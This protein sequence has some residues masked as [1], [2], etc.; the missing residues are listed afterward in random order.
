MAEPYHSD[1]IERHAAD[2]LSLEQHQ[3]DPMLQMSGGTLR[4]AGVAL[5][6]LAIAVVLFVVFYG[7][8]APAPGAGPAAAPPSTAAANTGA[9]QPAAPQPAAPQSTT[10][11]KG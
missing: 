1:D 6:A 7:L 8:N 10:P 2:P 3:P 4:A 9:P 11:G 5:V